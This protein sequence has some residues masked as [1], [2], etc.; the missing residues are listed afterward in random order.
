MN[1][2]SQI[3]FLHIPRTSGRATHTDLHNAG[4]K[5]STLSLD[6]YLSTKDWNPNSLLCGHFGN[7]PTKLGKKIQ[8][9]TLVRDVIS[10]TASM[11]IFAP[12]EMSRLQFLKQLIYDE[13]SGVFP[14]VANPQSSFIYSDISFAKRGIWG[15]Y[16]LPRISFS[17]AAQDVFNVVDFAESKGIKIYP[18]ENRHKFLHDVASCFNKNS[19]SIQDF[20]KETD[21][22]IEEFCMNNSKAILQK[23]HIDFELHSRAMLGSKHEHRTDSGKSMEN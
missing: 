23:H 3:Y 14:F 21:T 2:K 8:T 15:Q 7:H 11:S 17:N 4:V 6:A 5:L 13:P 22:E 20:P 12:A 9:F 1:C 19:V 16:Q 10:H 18:I